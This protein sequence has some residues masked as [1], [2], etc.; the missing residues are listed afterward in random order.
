MRFDAHRPGHLRGGRAWQD[1]EP[2]RRRCGHVARRQSSR[3]RPGPGRRLVLLQ[4]VAARPPSPLSA[5]YCVGLAGRQRGGV[6][7]GTPGPETEHH[8]R[9]NPRPCRTDVARRRHGDARQEAAAPS[10]AAR[11]IGTVHEGASPLPAIDGPMEPGGVAPRSAL[12][13][14]PEERPA[15][16]QRLSLHHLGRRDLHDPAGARPDGLAQGCRRRIRPMG[17]PA[18]RPRLPRSQ[19]AVH[20]WARLPDARRGARRQHGCHPCVRSGFHRLGLDRALLDDRRHRVA[21]GIRA[22]DQGQRPVDAAA[23]A[24]D[25]R[26]RFQAAGVSGARACNRRS[27]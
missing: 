15:V 17:V 16:V 26:A 24:G 8:P 20:G 14:E 11:R 3:R 7:Q 2:E 1:M 13:K 19:R 4:A 10:Q 25:C 5:A 21:Q 23:A 12:R 22:A 27:R 6:H 9:A 18:R